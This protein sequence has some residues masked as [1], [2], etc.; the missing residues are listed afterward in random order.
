MRN[1]FLHTETQI[2]LTQLAIQFSETDPQVAGPK[3]SL[4][5]SSSVFAV[6]G[7]CLYAASTMSSTVIEYFSARAVQ[8][9]STA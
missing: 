3:A 2:Y 1:G 4:A 6:E 5:A 9:Q 8:A 7:C